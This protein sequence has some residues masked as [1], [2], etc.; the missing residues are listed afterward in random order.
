MGH[1]KIILIRLKF[2]YI[3]WAPTINPRNLILKQKK[4]HFENLANNSVF[5]NFFKTKR[6]YLRYSFLVREKISIL[7]K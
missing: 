7:F 4:K 5:R 6:K 1:S 3:P 2:I